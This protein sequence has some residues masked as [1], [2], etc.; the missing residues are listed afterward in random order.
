MALQF[1]P[2]FLGSLLGTNAPMASAMGLPA[3]IAGWGDDLGIPQAAIPASALPQS[4]M[5]TEAPRSRRSILDI[6]G[7]IGDV[8]AKVGG[9]DAQYQPQ[10]DARTE[11]A[12]QVDTDAMRKQQFEMQQRQG[13]QSLEKG[14][15]DIADEH[16]QVL[17]QATRGLAAVYERGGAPALEKAWPML[18]QQLQIPPQQAALFGEALKSDPEGTITALHSALTDP[19]KQGS[20][21]SALQN[22]SA[23]NQIL[24][25]QGKSAADEFMR[26]AQPQMEGLTQAQIA[27]QAREDRKFNYERGKDARDFHYRQQTD[28]RN[29]DAKNASPG[30]VPLTKTQLGVVNMKLRSLPALERQ[31][32]EVQRLG[33][34]LDSPTGGSH[35][36]GYIGGRVPGGLVGGIADRYDKAVA[37]L[38]SQVRQ[39]TKVPG[40][41]SISDYETRLGGATLPTR[42][43]SAAGRAQAASDLA[44]LISGIRTGYTEMAG[45]APAA[46]PRTTGTLSP[47]RG[48]PAARGGWKV[49]EVK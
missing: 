9:A 6:I 16:R 24:K 37:S 22:Y 27:Q 21:T 10:V 32:Q 12:R 29:F 30:G 20:P 43:D 26:F 25:T 33:Q 41:G 39:F 45:P 15:L 18:A 46:R 38:Q 19:A 47:R 42:S 7:G 23:Y 34:Q 40:E 35:A 1:Q 36:T 8:F 4:A 2:N 5:Q 48:A 3:S 31:L 14:G 49:I 11:R 44:A 28:Q 13:E 17:G